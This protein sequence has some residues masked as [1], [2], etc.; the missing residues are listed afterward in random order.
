VRIL[1]LADLLRQFGLN[2]GQTNEFFVKLRIC[3]VQGLLLRNVVNTS[4]HD[5]QLILLERLAVKLGEKSVKLRH[6]QGAWICQVQQAC[7]HALQMLC[8]DFLRNIQTENVECAQV[9]LLHLLA[10]LVLVL[11]F[12]G[13]FFGQEFL[14]FV[15]SF[16]TVFK[17]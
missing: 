4:L 2:L 3:C 14:H 17:A 16:F 15:L 11:V 7:V 1:D 9:L 10:F 13:V 5:W 8:P 6:K 12:L